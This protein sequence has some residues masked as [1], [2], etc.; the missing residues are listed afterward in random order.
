V[1]PAMK[2]ILIIRLSS[3]GDIVLASPL[4]RAVRKAYPLAQID[5]LIKSEY[6]DLVRFN[7]NLSSIIELKSNDKEEL[8]TLKRTLRRTRYDIILDLHN[9]LR[10]RYLRWFSGAKHIKVV[11]KRIIKRFLLISFKWNFYRTVISVVDRYLETGKRFA[12]QNDGQGLEVTIPN[13]TILTVKA[14]MEKY[15]L[16]R[17]DLVVGIAPSARHYTKRW[18]PERYVELGTQVAR[19]FNAKLL[20]FG[21]KF[22]QDYCGDIA[23]MINAN[24]G[25]TTA[26][27]FAGKL[28]LLETAAVLDSCSIVV[29]N[30]SGIMHLAAA[31]KKK[32][33]AIFGST[34][35]EFGFFPFGTQSAVVENENLSCRPCS[36]IGSDRCPKNHFKCMKDIHVETVLSTIQKMAEER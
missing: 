11:N 21:S 9:S 12:I 5:F 35:K 7:P 23:Q 15:Q 33:V 26:E 3:I 18:F 13:D 14:M 6:T 29:T 28:N 19:K 8:K 36:H 22:E 34:V 27:S 24:L 2:K 30:D 10:S 32:N 17:Y 25:S 20:I 31:R 4:I 1:N 16:E